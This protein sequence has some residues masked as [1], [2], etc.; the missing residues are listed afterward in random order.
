M[1]DRITNWTAPTLGW[2]KINFDVGL[3]PGSNIV[4][5]GLVARNCHN[6]VLGWAF[7]SRPG[8]LSSTLGE[9]LAFR[10]AVQCSSQVGWPCVVFEGDNRVAMDQV[11]M[12]CEGRKFVSCGLVRFISSMLS[13]FVRFEISSISRDA[14]CLAH[15]IATKQI[16]LPSALRLH[17]DAF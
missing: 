7:T 8:L 1:R 4:N 13:R 10:V 9:L 11:R 3:P 2:V 16:V 15:D 14:N 5:I 12:A 6:Q 17:A